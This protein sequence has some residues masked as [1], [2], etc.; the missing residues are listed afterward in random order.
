MIPSSQDNKWKQRVKFGSDSCK[1]SWHYR[2]GH[3]RILMMLLSL[4]RSGISHLDPP[5][6]WIR[7]FLTFYW[8]KMSRCNWEAADK[9]GLMDRSHGGRKDFTSKGEYGYRG[10]APSAVG[11]MAGLGGAV[12]IAKEGMCR[13]WRWGTGTQRGGQKH[14]VMWGRESPAAAWR[15]L[16]IDDYRGI[17]SCMD[18]NCLVFPSPGQKKKKNKIQDLTQLLKHGMLPFCLPASAACSLLLC[19][20][21]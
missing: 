2:E 14:P 13:Q 8:G 7:F 20:L 18:L 9:H 4:Q 19:S 6:L 11:C 5:Q 12:G 16:G 3:W 21:K 10:T 1:K 15:A 17:C